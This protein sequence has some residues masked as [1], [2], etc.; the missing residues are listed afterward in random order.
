MTSGRTLYQEV[1]HPA[2]G[3]AGH[4]YRE[5][6]SMAGWVGTVARHVAQNWHDVEILT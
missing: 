2:S 5:E 6:G 3:A 1:C 4:R